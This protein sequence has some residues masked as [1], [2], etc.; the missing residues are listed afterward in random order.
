L[1]NSQA[2]LDN[3]KAINYGS[4]Q[5]SDLTTVLKPPNKA[6]ETTDQLLLAPEQGYVQISQECRIN[7]PTMV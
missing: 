3:Y 2:I 4:Y 5:Y 6:G 7:G 1:I